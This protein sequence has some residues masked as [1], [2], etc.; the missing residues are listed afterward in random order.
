[1]LYVVCV[2]T[3]FDRVH[4]CLY[5]FCGR[6]CIYIFLWMME[7]VCH[8]K[9]QFFFFIF[10]KLRQKKGPAG[11]RRII[12]LFDVV[13]KYDVFMK[14]NTHRHGACLRSHE[15]NNKS[16][17][18]YDCVCVLSF[19][20]FYV[21]IAFRGIFDGGG[22]RLMMEWWAMGQEY[23]WRYRCRIVFILSTIVINLVP[24]LFPAHI[25][26]VTRKKKNTITD[27]PNRIHR[28]SPDRYNFYN[29]LSIYRCFS[30]ISVFVWWAH[31]KLPIRHNII[32]LANNQH[33][34]A[35]ALSSSSALL[36][37]W[38]GIFIQFLYMAPYLAHI[39]EH[40]LDFLY[41]IYCDLFLVVV[42]VMTI[43]PHLKKRRE[44]N[45]GEK[46]AGPMCVLSM[47]VRSY[48]RSVAVIYIH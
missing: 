29:L 6:F 9:I 18:V 28:C 1:M 15:H 22:V 7:W 8:S 41:A 26:F 44:E 39:F 13:D 46:C 21:A 23:F 36:C 12:L 33:M 38:N 34:C 10:D 35:W 32:S 27:R 47:L 11:T 30:G 5:C 24:F 42:L 48:R 17:A 14:F 3:A 25:S 16:M 20:G 4:R 19:F 31:H 2:S 45:H 40:L 37:H 43:P